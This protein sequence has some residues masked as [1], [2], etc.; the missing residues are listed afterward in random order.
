MTATSRTITLSGSTSS[1]EWVCPPLPPFSAF[2]RAPAL[3]TE[4]ARIKKSEFIASPAIPRAV[5]SWSPAAGFLGTKEF[6]PK[7]MHGFRFDS[8]D[9]LL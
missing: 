7:G 9:I 2:F 1:A 4:R 6:A 3:G 8:D 5:Q